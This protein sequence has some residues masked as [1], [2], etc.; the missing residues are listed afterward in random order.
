M[1]VVVQYIYETV[2]FGFI[3]SKRY[4]IKAKITKNGSKNK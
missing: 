1:I 3:L 4:S 2:A